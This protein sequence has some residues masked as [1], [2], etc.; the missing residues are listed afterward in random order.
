[1]TETSSQTNNPSSA[2]NRLD[3][4]EAI[5]YIQLQGQSLRPLFQQ[6]EDYPVFIEMLACAARLEGSQILAYCLLNQSIHLLLRAPA[7]TPAEHSVYTFMRQLN[8]DYTQ[9]F[10]EQ[11]SRHG[12]VF[13]AQFSCTLLE[14]Q[15]YLAKAIAML[16]R[17]PLQYG[18]VAEASI[19]P[20]SSHNHYL[21]AE[22]EYNDWLDLDTGLNIIAKQRSAKQRYY[23]DFI[24][25]SPQHLLDE[26]DWCGGCHSDYLALA[27]N[28]YINNLLP[29]DP[30]IPA[31][32]PSLAL[33]TLAVC[34]E[35]G[36]NPREL[37]QLRRHRQAFEVRAQIVT[38]AQRW[39]IAEKDKACRFLDCSIEIIDTTLRSL[40][41]SRENFSYKL[42]KKIA[43]QLGITAAEQ[44]SSRLTDY[45]PEQ[46][47]E[48]T[49]EQQSVAI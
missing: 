35:Y 48:R 28:D 12:S 39:N 32:P 46:Q 49:P 25:H 27:S 13:Q 23:R 38:L 5:Y 22:R 19:Y 2:K 36:M 15:L 31:T 17:L 26:I 33:L 16:H 4:P 29:K 45:T 24:D 10:N 34:R 1:M 42:E 11:Q 14:P 18:L 43:R 7:K 3:I 21:N 44:H 9:Y 41:A 40:Q 30:K 37:L 8:S 47:K 6:R 20:W